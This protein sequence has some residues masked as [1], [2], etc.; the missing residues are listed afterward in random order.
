[1]EV[2]AQGS[3]TT[4]PGSSK[5]QIVIEALEPAGAGA[6]MALLD[7]RKRKFA[8]EGLVRR[9]TARSRVRS[10]RKSSASSRRRPAP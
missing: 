8:A 6:L 2:V 3:I 1:M 5:Y 7:E 10:C 4:F 9:G